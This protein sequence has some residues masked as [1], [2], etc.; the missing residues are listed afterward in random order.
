MKKLIKNILP[1]GLIKYV[2]RRRLIKRFRRVNPDKNKN[3]L[4]NKFIAKIFFIGFDE[5]PFVIMPYCNG[6]QKPI[7]N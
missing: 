6:K 2:E 3:D 5:A 1:Y 4:S 7:D